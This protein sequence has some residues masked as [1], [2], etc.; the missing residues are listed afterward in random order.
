MPRLKSQ[1]G[2]SLFLACILS[3][4]APA[5]ASAADCAILLHGLART[6]ASLS[7][8]GDALRNDGYTLI[9]VDYPSRKATVERLA[10]E[11]VGPAVAACRAA[12]TPQ[13]HFVTH[14][15]GGILVRYYL[16]RESL[17][18]LGRVVM[19]S[20]PNQGSEVVDALRDV[21]GFHAFHG[22]AGGQLG[23]DA[24]SLPL[25]LGPVSY[26]VGVITGNKSVNPLLSLL[27]PGEDDGKVSIER[28]KVNGM[29]DF[30]VVPH[31]HPMIMN[32]EQV[33]SQSKHFLRYGKFDRVTK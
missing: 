6:D 22:P 32:S 14:S 23:T 13:I 20:P 27:I 33:I 26:P 18:E 4:A 19:L 1:E 3:W 9:N 7:R 15:M 11:H 28:S 5:L 2:L 29:A 10:R 16:A 25:R 17:E 21:P 30:M 24:E 31:S 8:L 12:R